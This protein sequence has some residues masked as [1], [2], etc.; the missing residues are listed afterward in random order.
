MAVFADFDDAL[1]R[2]DH[3]MESHKLSILIVDHNPAQREAYAELLR[4]DGHEVTAVSNGRE[5]LE[6]ATARHYQLVLS[7]LSMPQMTGDELFNQLQARG[8]ESLFVLMGATT[9]D[10]MREKAPHCFSYLSKP[11]HPDELSR[12]VADCCFTTTA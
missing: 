12:L 6:R 10:A 1:V 5:A 2:A 4:L 3:I 9:V 7:D 11:F 8:C